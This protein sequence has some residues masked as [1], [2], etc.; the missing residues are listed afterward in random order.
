MNRIVLVMLLVLALGCHTSRKK[1]DQEQLTAEQQV[2]REQATRRRHYLEAHPDLSPEV[3]NAIARGDVL[4][5]MTE[6]DV[7]ASIG[8]PDQIGSTTTEHG[9]HEQWLY[10]S[11]SPGK[12]YLD[13]D[14]GTLTSWQAGH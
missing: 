3:S 9:T 4:T 11:G 12:E 14:D 8:E 2:A 7:R 5:G 6:S 13:F 10:K 1:K